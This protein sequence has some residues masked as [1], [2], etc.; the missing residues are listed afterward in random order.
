MSTVASILTA[1]GYRLFS[2]GTS[3]D[4]TSEPSQAECIQW[5]NETTLW[6]TGICAA[7]GS[8]LGRTTGS[9]TTADGTASYSDLSDMYIPYEKGWIVKTYSRDEIVLTTEL[10]S[11]NYDPSD[12]NEPEKYYIDGSNNVVFLPTPDDTYT[13]KIPYWAVPTALTL[14]TDTMPFN[15][16]FDN[17]YIEALV[18]RAQNR[19][20]YDLSFELKWFGFLQDQIRQAIE[21]RKN[22]NVSVGL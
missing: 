1:V 13:V 22:I 2:D 16:I 12:E 7:N 21:L 20:E 8:E 18:L 9:I 3:I 11:I 6:I 15:G 5:I 14:T 17:Q 4:T 10:D 19:D